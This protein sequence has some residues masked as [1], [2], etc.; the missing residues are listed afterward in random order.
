LPR[1][2]DCCIGCVF[3]AYT[4]TAATKLGVGLRT[5]QDWE[6]GRQHAARV[7]AHLITKDLSERGKGREASL[8]KSNL[9]KEANRLQAAPAKKE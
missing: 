5:Y 4:G 7:G 8:S 9:K 6:Q 1:R 2:P 3:G